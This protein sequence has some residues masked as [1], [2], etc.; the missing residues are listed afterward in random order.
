LNYLQ[1]DQLIPTP[2]AGRVTLQR[3]LNALRKEPDILY[4]VCHGAIV[5]GEPRLLLENEDGTGKVVLGRE[6]FDGLVSLR[7]LP[8]LVV[9][10]SCQG[11]GTDEPSAAGGSVLVALGPRLAEAGAPAAL[12]MQGDLAME[13]SREVL[14]PLFP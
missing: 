14:P 1:K 12:A 5:D 9:L 11:G 4:L 6:L 2:T 7:T 3:L 10:I 8:R 13:T